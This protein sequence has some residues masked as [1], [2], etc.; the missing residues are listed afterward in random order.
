[1]KLQI[2]DRNWDSF[3]PA[4]FYESYRRRILADREYKKMMEDMMAS[5]EAWKIEDTEETLVHV[6]NGAIRALG[7]SN[8]VFPAGL[9]DFRG[10]INYQVIQPDEPRPMTARELL[11]R[12]HAENSGLT[13]DY[14]DQLRERLR[15]REWTYQPTYQQNTSIGP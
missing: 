11:A 7:N 12:Q 5:A 13:R 8:R 3:H 10:G 2:I 15:S 4:L 6:P 9:P 1:M 14:I